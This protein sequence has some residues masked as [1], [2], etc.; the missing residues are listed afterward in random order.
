[1]IGV[2]MKEQGGSYATFRYETFE[3][4]NSFCCTFYRL[5]SRLVTINSYVL[6]GDELRLLFEYF[7][8]SYVLLLGH[9]IQRD[10]PRNV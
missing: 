8:S 5:L 1:M 9:E 4:I 10:Y 6:H 2:V 7:A 3:I